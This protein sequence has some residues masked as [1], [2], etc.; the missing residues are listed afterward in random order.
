MREKFK[1]KPIVAVLLPI[2]LLLGVVILITTSIGPLLNAALE[3]PLVQVE[4]EEGDQVENINTK[5]EFENLQVIAKEDGI[6]ELKYDETYSVAPLDEKKEELSIPLYQKESLTSKKVMD[7]FEKMAEEVKDFNDGEEEESEEKVPCIKVMESETKGSLYFKFAKDKKQWIKIQRKT[8]S[9][10]DV[11]LASSND[12]NRIQQLVHFESLDQALTESIS[13][14]KQAEEVESSQKQE[15]NEDQETAEGKI[16]SE[17][18]RITDVEDG[19]QKTTETN[20]SKTKEETNTEEKTSDSDKEESKLPELGTSESYKNILAVQTAKTDKSIAE[21]EEK[22]YKEKDSLKT[23][24]IIEKN[25]KGSKESDESEPPIIIRDINIRTKTGTTSF[26]IGSGNKPGYDENED[27]DVVRTFDQVSYL[28]SF[29]IQN[30]SLSE[31][32]TNI[33]YRVV[34]ELDNAV[35]VV[36][37]IPKNI[38]EIANGTYVDNGDGSSYSVGAMES[39]ISDTGQVFVPVILNV[40]GADHGD[41]V[42][43]KFKLEIVDAD[44]KKSGKKETFTKIYDETT[45]SKLK[46][47]ETTISAKPAVSVKLEQGSIEAGTAIGNSSSNVKVYDVGAKTVLAPLPGRAT[48]DYRGSTFPKGAI[49]YTVK[50]KGTYQIGAGTPM[51]MT[52]SMYNQMDLFG[53]A[54]AYSDRTAAPWQEKG[55]INKAQLTSPLPVPH[56]KTSAIYTAQPTGDLSKIGVYDSGVFAN[57]SYTISNTSYARTLNPYTYNMTGERIQTATDKPF[58]SLEMVFSWDSKKTMDLAIAGSWNRCEMTLYIDSISYDGIT[59]ANETSITYPEVFTPPGSY[60]AGPIFIKQLSENPLEEVNMEENYPDV[61]QNLGNARLN[62]GEEFYIA[63]FDVTANTNVRGVEN[64][65]MWDPSAFEYDTSRKP[66]VLFGGK[67]DNITSKFRYGVAKTLGNTPPYTNQVLDWTA[68]SKLYSWYDT[69]EDAQAVGQISAVET[70]SKFKY[71]LDIGN[72]RMAPRI[73]AIVINP[74]GDKTPAGNAIVLREAVQFRVKSGEISFDPGIHRI[75]EGAVYKPTIYDSDGKAIS[76]PFYYWNWFGDTAYVNKFKITTK[77]DVEKSAY[78]SKE[79]INIKINGVTSGTPTVDYDGTLTT[80]L[81]KGIHYKIGTA[82][83]GLGQPMS[84]PTP[85][86]N[87]DGTTTLR[88]NFTKLP[89]NT[90]IEVNFTAIADFT[91]LSFKDTGYTDSLTVKTIGEMWVSGNPALKDTS[92]EAIRSSTDVFIEQLIQQVILSK[93]T[94]KPS[95]EVGETDPVGQNNDITYKVKL[96]NESAAPIPKVRLLEVLPYDGD[97][98]GTIF[99]GNYTLENLQVTGEAQ[100]NYNNAVVDEHTNPNTIT[101]WTEFIPGTHSIS[102]VKNAKSI[103]V[104]HDSLGVG[105]EI[106]LTVTLRPTSQKAGDVLINN[107]SM[108]SEF[109]LPVNSQTAVTRVYGRDLTGYVWYDEDYNGLMDQKPDG[110]PKDPVGNIPVKLYRTSYKDTNYKNELVEKALTG[111]AFIDDSG[112]SNIKTDINGKYEFK[113]LP[114]GKYIA[115]F[116][117]GDLITQKIVIVTKQSEGSDESKNSKADPDTFKTPEYKQPELND[118]PTLL[119]GTDKVHHVKHV[120]A[121]LTPLSK[122]RLFKYE[123]GTV[124]DKN[125]DGKLSEAEIESTDTH[126]LEGAEF[127]LYKGDSTNA[128]DKIGDPVSTDKNGWLEFE[129]GLPPGEYTIVETKAPNGF[130]LLK[131][132]IKVT[133]PTY[134]YIVKVH[135]PDKGQTKLPFTGGTKAMR[136]I[137]IAAAVLMVVG[138]TGVFLHF[139]PINVKGGK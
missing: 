13:S 121:G 12:T 33:R 117:V 54:P 74:P 89:L 34:A 41:K 11:K 102:D 26:D 39:T 35:V 136:I 8:S 80:T 92:A 27:N 86:N 76:F 107:T 132:P 93:E 103:L 32:Y 128:A 46:V 44:N 48:G 55:P 17:E 115:E 67:K 97:S 24:K 126:A 79:E 16:A 21:M 22:T 5:K 18:K 125:G 108:N 45:N 98:R 122:I 28:L 25:F 85:V 58:S 84:E 87:P 127:Q 106:E 23:P 101:G 52:S 88:W 77:T 56:A 6:F 96:L 40:Y 68:T 51:N 72:T 119:T 38:G 71:A 129:G 66:Y 123:E 99:H 81:P 3:I 64:I 90:G 30:N 10:L 116:M 95:I 50:Q 65:L 91:Q 139:R 31:N 53:F 42:K 70:I 111:E 104:S 15:E 36:D 19:S 49:S 138:M 137:L 100:I 109:N 82:T 118:L 75:P 114:E 37:G 133:V 130:E 20:E 94:T 131:D 134:N 112:N 9:A 57:S 105:K 120:N 59:T 135:V 62:Q 69:P 29:S 83:D 14:S 110:S 2:T 61:N 124:V 60:A 43:P 7:I 4:N 47:S 113:N 78:Q 73:P 1:Q 63:S